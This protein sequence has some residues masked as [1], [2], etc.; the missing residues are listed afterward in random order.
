M[1]NT[2]GLRAAEKVCKKGKAEE[3]KYKLMGLKAIRMLLIGENYFE[4]YTS[5]PKKDLNKTVHK[6]YFHSLHTLLKLKF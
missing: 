1:G 2:E 5:L 6:V 3:E 4:K